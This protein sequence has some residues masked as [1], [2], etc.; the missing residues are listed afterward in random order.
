M[1]ADLV[2]AHAR[3]T[4][5]PDAAWRRPAVLIPVALLLVAA[6]AFGVWQTMQARRARWARLEA[7]PEIERL[8]LSGRSMSA[9]R[10]ARDGG[11]VRPRR[12]RAPARGMVAR[13]IS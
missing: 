10:L 13:S 7:V 9:V 1:R 12:G 2:A 3:L 6:A 5:P 8:H 4:R 11:A